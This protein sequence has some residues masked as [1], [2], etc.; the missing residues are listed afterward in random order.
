[1]SDTS[2]A[3]RFAAGD[4]SVG[5][6]LNRTFS[7][8]TGNFLTFFTV[9]TVASLPTVLLSESPTLMTSGSPTF[10][11]RALSGENL[12]LTIG[13]LFLGMFVSIVLYTLSQA[14]VLFGAF[15]DMRGRPVSLVESLQVGLRRFFPIIGLAISTSFLAGLAIIFF[16]VPGLILFTMWFVATP[17]CVVERL[18]PF[19]SMGRSRRLTKGYRW[20]VFGLILLLVLISVIVSPTLGAALGAMGNKFLVIIGSLVW[21]GIW[22]AFYA[23]AAVVAY[24]DLRAAKEGIDIEQ[25]AAVFD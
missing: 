16:I 7:V 12:T 9:T 20:R 25:I 14:I 6:V 13:F 19:A 23:I 22:G 10:T 8:L 11:T 18:G 15:Q 1:M 4:F 21:S 24:H 5:R 17:V 2:T 3:T